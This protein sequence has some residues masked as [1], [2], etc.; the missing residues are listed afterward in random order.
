MYI[1]CVYKEGEYVVLLAVMM[2][3]NCVLPTPDIGTRQCTANNMNTDFD[4]LIRTRNEE[5]S[6]RRTPRSSSILCAE[7]TDL[8]AI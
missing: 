1:D 6:I 7:S 2:Q 5:F 4:I 8:G 3:T